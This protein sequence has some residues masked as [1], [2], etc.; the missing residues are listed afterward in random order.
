MTKR[1]EP[2]A[3]N[4]ALN[5]PRQKLGLSLPI[6]MGIVIASLLVLLL[7]FF[8]LSILIFIAITATCWVIVR[9]H[10]RMFQLWGLSFTQRSYY[11]P[12]KR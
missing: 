4:Q 11:D 10:P 12:R 2:V 9:K 6:W 3:I 1:G 8:F 5:K 7:R